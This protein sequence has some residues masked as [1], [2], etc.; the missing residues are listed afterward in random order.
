MSAKRTKATIKPSPCNISGEMGDKISGLL[1]ECGIEPVTVPETFEEPVPLVLP[2][3]SNIGQQD[4]E[5]EAEGRV[6]EWSPPSLGYD[7]WTSHTI[8]ANE[9]G[10]EWNVEHINGALIDERATKLQ[11]QEFKKVY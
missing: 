3:E 4:T 8:D 6:I 5:V 2:D 11:D 1:R 9:A 10:P 7:P